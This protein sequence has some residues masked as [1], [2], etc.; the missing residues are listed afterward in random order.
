VQPALL[1]LDPLLVPLL[2]PTL[3]PSVTGPFRARSSSSSKSWVCSPDLLSTVAMTSSRAT[4]VSMRPALGR[5][6]ARSRS[7]ARSLR[8]LS[9][10]TSSRAYS[11]LPP[12]TRATRAASASGSPYRLTRSAARAGVD[13]GENDTGWQRDAMVGS[14]FSG[15]SVTRMKWTWAGGSSSVLRNALAASALKLSASRNM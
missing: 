10:V 8:A 6:R 1:P 12:A 9:D 7:S 4:S 3:G 14:T 2:E 11:R 15:R 5:S 13:T